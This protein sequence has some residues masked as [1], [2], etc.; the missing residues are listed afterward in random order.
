MRVRTALLSTFFIFVLALCV[1]GGWSAW[2]LREL[3]GASRRIIADNYDS[4]VAAQRMKESL[5]RQDS[6]VL[7]LLL[8]EHERARTQLA[9]HRRRFD[10]SL[11]AAANNITESGEAATVERIRDLRT[12]Y[13]A[14]VDAL[15]ARGTLSSQDYFARLGPHFDQLRGEL[16]RLLQLNQDAMQRKSRQA[17]A[18]ARAYVIQAL[19]LAAALAAASVVVAGAIGRRVV[20][21]LA[22]L[23]QATDRMSAGDLDVSAPVAAGPRELRDLALSFNRMQDRLRELR[24]SDLGRLRAA[25]QLAESAIDSLYD[26]VIVTDVDGRVTRANRAA[27]DVFGRDAVAV[28]RPISELG[29]DTAIG[30]AVSQAIASGRATTSEG[31]ASVTRLTTAG[32]ERE[33]RLRT[34]PMRGET[35]TLMGS[36]TL[37]ED[38]THLR[39][40]DRVKSDFV[41]VASHELRTPLTSLL[42]GVQ[43]LAEPSTGTLT[44]RQ[45]TLLGI[46]IQDAE[47]L[48]HLMQELLDVGRLESGRDVM[49]FA[50]V[51]LPAVVET[52]L[53]QLRGEAERRGLSLTSQVSTT[54]TPVMADRSRVERVLTNLI[55]NAIRATKAGGVTVR[56]DA[57]P[58]HATV[59]VSDTG[60]GIDPDQMPRLF[61]RFNRGAGAPSGGAGLGLFIA[62]Q[63][64]EAHGGRIWAHS[65]RGRGAVFS[66]TLPNASPPPTRSVGQPAGQS[67]G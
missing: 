64:V 7:F 62:R 43:L 26:P 4:V 48:R 38:V 59:T 44:E 67:V 36:V 42:M 37:L 45:R 31:G 10:Y 13:Y 28:G 1:L 40:I 65:D 60:P 17:E 66:F 51:N 35:G 15:G 52:V 55:D 34:T 14:E 53:A 54:L 5:E 20:R 46:C 29:G 49:A 39:E 61:E 27:E 19:V 11:L 47:R 16:D 6:A 58:D 41:A 2:Q 18:A 63:I 33:Y 25:Q 32:A 12:R 23:T 56:A 9:E 24:R 30:A 3:G 50:P 57:A 21:P 22:G 8:G